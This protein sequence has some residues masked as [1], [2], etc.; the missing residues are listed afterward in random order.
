[1][2]E[3]SLRKVLNRIQNMSQFL[4]PSRWGHLDTRV[5]IRLLWITVQSRQPRLHDS[6]PK[7]PNWFLSPIQTG[8][9]LCEKMIRL[10]FGEKIREQVHFSLKWKKI[11]SLIWEKGGLHEE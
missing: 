10:I 1:M 4:S 7:H 2:G 5:S 3:F 6:F 8:A 11:F 9:E